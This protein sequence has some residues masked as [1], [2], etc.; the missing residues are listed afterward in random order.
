MNRIDYLTKDGLKIIQHPE[1]FSFS[2]DALLL[3]HFATLP[4]K[5][6][7]VDLCAGNGAVGLLAS[8][9]TEADITMIELQEQLANMAKESVILNHK[10][11]QIQVIQAPLQDGLSYIEHDSV[12]A[13]VCNPPYFATSKTSKQNPNPYLAIARHEIYT[14]LDDIMTL[15][16]Q[17]LKTRG[18]I[19]LV[20]RPN[21]LL[22]IIQAMTKANIEAKTLRFIYPKEGKE[23]NML[24]IEG[25]KGGKKSGL[26]VLPPFIVHHQDGRYTEEM[27]AIFQ[28]G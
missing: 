15:A 4:K 1:V 3:G 19:T 9:R 5:G 10:E 11:E 26:K 21:R 13:I 17:L 18:K 25:V 28:H 22:D 2:V 12:D 27:E 24:L 8:Q 14:N 16:K 20:H 7:I 23:A 6:H